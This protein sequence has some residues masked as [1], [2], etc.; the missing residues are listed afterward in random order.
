MDFS[1]YNYEQHFGGGSFSGSSS[2]IKTPFFGCS[3]DK[4]PALFFL[5]NNPAQISMSQINANLRTNL[6][7]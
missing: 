7:S 5:S 6:S 3:G 4:P 1:K 2:T